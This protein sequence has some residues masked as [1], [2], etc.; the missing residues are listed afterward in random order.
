MPRQSVSF[1]LASALLSAGRAFVLPKIPSKTLRKALNIRRLGD[2]RGYLNVPHYWAV[3]YHEGHTKPIT[4]KRTN[5][6]LVWFKNPK[7]DPR[8]SSGFPIR[9]NQVRSL[10]KD[11]FRAARKK[12][13]IIVTKRS[14]FDGR[15][16]RGR[17]FFS[18]RGGMTGFSK[19]ADRVVKKELPK[20]LRAE[21]ARRGLTK[22]VIKTTVG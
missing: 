18:N 13:Q 11:E 9:K 15:A 16:V 20:L 6:F 1:S 12:N 14:P 3:F 8:I 2:T 22:L 19:K 4:P 7:L 17:N 5:G 21:F 10:T